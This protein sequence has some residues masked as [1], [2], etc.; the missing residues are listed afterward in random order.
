M[1]DLKDKK[2]TVV[3]LGKSGMQA[4]LLLHEMGAFPKVSD[5]RRNPE[6]E[7][8]AEE[9]SKRNIQIEL[10]SHT[11]EF[12][13]D[14]ELIV[15]SPGVSSESPALKWAEARSIP[16]ISEIELA[17]SLCKAPIIAISGTN[18]KSTVTSLVGEIL[19][20]SG[21]KVSVCG[22]I[23]LP[24]SGEVLSLDE[25]SVVVLE[26]SSFQLETIKSFKP[27]IACLLNIAQDHF[28]RYENMEAYFDAKKKIFS[29]QDETDY[30]VLNFDSHKIRALKKHIKSNS[31]YFSKHRLSK[32]YDGAYV[33]N[34]QILIRQEK[35]FKWIADQEDLHLAGDHNLQN[36]L[37]AALMTFLFGVKAESI[38]KSLA[39]FK[40]LP[41]RF[42]QVDII[43]GVRFIDDSKATNVD[44]VVKALEC[45]NSP[46]ILI[47]GG[48]DKENDYRALSKPVKEKVKDLILLGESKEKIASVIGKTKPFHFVDSLSQAVNLAF[49][50]A[51]RR[52]IVLLSP[53]CASFDMFKDY[54]ERGEVF[55]QA[56]AALKKA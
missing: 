35:K 38:K 9:L 54:K 45:C 24:F 3:G 51:S 41:H 12:V 14:S 37:A 26:I 18:G 47:A 27:K 15:T 40:T 46:V 30:A 16:I 17:Y 49:Q 5:N 29:N 8:S 1:L 4:A 34:G 39:S 22:N 42:E 44:S 52:D 36:Y 2:V 13:S 7:E 56:V 33:E 25:N 55:R 43:N 48:R 6:I 21:K 11:E 50:K 19:R 10:G 53:I 32:E 28:D 31:L 23:G 20:E